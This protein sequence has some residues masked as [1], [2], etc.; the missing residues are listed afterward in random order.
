NTSGEIVP[1]VA[2]ASGRYDRAEDIVGLLFAM[3]LLSIAWLSTQESIAINGQWEGIK[4]ATL[5]LPLALIVIFTG[6]VTGTM[7]AGYFP[8]L[9]L[10]F[11]SKKEMQEEVQ[12]KAAQTFQLLRLRNTQAAT[13][14]LIYVS[15]YERMV[16]IIGDD[17]ISEKLSQDDWDQVCAIVVNGMKSGKPHTAL[18]EAVA[19][20]GKLL[21]QHFPRQD[22][23]E[24]EL[25]NKLHL[26]H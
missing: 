6:F 25:P 2:T 17:A 13:G 5:S 22:N 11:I 20:C 14:V 10:P 26:V 16:S 18:E 15:L 9:R 12:I 23:D 24:N 4:T 21:S 3:I 1:V 8:V 7:L 19:Q